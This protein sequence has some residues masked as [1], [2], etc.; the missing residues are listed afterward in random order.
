M[1]SATMR[2]WPRA[3]QVFASF[4]TITAIASWLFI[5][6]MPRSETWAD[7]S[8]NVGERVAL[9]MELQVSK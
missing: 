7:S 3:A 5:R 8:A 2:R 1:P 4:V 9:F 6:R